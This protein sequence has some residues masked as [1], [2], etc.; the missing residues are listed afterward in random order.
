[1]LRVLNSLSY[2][3]LTL[4]LTVPFAANAAQ[5]H[6]TSAANK[7]T[8]VELYT[9]EGCSSCP[10]A[11]RWLSNLGEGQF[12]EGQLV[13]LAL[14]VDYWDYI[15]WKDP[16]SKGEYS[17]RQRNIGNVNNLRTIY[18]PQFVLNGEDLRGWY[19]RNGTD[20]SIEKINSEKAQATIDL[21]LTKGTSTLAVDAKV[22]LADGQSADGYGL[23]L[24]LFENNLISDISRGENAGKT[25]HH[26]YVV[27]ELLGPYKVAGQTV[28]LSEKFSLNADWKA[29][30]L[31]VAAFVQNRKTG[32]VLQA[33]MLKSCT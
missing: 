14:H 1:M 27:R 16:Y 28:S 30:N 18:T 3:G 24:A 6:G 19:K 29:E 25:L 21:T 5:C 2:L 10:P 9:S 7:A 26:D 23:Y 22:V 17:K 33:M 13:P 15:G 20:G 8:L 11:D 31:G 32:D 12:E 4:A